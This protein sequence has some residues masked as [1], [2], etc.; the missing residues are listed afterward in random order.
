MDEAGV[1]GVKRAGPSPSASATASH[2]ASPRKTPNAPAKSG[3]KRGKTR[4]QDTNGA[5]TEPRSASRKLPFSLQEFP[6][7]AA[8]AQAGFDVATEF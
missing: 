7:A 4:G 6:E 3:A 5:A 8:L 2:A 1:S